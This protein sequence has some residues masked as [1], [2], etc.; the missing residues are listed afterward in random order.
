MTTYATTLEAR[1]EIAEGTMAFHL[2]K[3][4]GFDFKPGQAIDVILTLKASAPEDQSTRHT[5]ST[6]TACSCGFTVT[7]T[8]AS[9]T[10]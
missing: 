8:T 3:P 1:E 5:F 10:R 7:P 6:P 2:R 9:T 4:I